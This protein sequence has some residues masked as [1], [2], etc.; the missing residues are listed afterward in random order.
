MKRRFAKIFSIILVIALMAGTLPI[1]QAVFAAENETATETE[2]K[3]DKGDND[4]GSNEEKTPTPKP[5]PDVKKDKSEEDST[6]TS[7][8]DDQKDTPAPTTIGD[9]DKK[10]IETTV[11]ETIKPEETEPTESKTEETSPSENPDKEDGKETTEPGKIPEASVNSP[12]RNA[13]VTAIPSVSIRIDVPVVGRTPDYTATFLGTPHY[14]SAT[15][16]NGNYRNDI[17]WKDLTINQYVNPDSGV[18][19]SEHKY[20]VTI[21]LTADENYYFTSSTRATVNDVETSAELNS[22]QLRVQYTFPTLGTDI[23]AVSIKLDAPVAGKKPDY[24]AMFPTGAHYSTDAYNKDNYLNGIMWWDDTACSAVNTS[25]GVFQAGHKYRV[26]IY[27]AV[28]EGYSFTGATSVTLNDQEAFKNL[29]NSQ[30]LYIVYSFQKL[31]GEAGDLIR[32]AAITLNE[33]ILGEAPDYTAEL[34]SGARYYSAFSNDGKYYNDIAWKDLDTNSYLNPSSG[35][36]QAGHTYQVTIFLTAQ[37]GYL[38]STNYQEV[39]LNGMPVNAIDS[40]KRLEVI[41]TFPKLGNANEG[42]TESAG[43]YKYKITNAKS[44]GS[45]TVTLIGVSVAKTSVSI[46]NNVVIK[47][48]IYKVTRI[49]TKAFYGN[50]AITSLSIGANITII[51]A[52]AFEGC[53]NLLKV[54]GGKGLKTIGTSAFAKCSKLK[55]FS[56]SSAVLSKIGNYAFNKDSKLKTIYIKYTTKL[57]KSGVKKSLKGSKVKTVKVKKSKVKKYKKYFKKKNSGRSVK[58]KK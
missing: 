25:S 12:R 50:K 56:I 18:F 10:P 31:E 34:P 58:V 21:F 54:T 17:I 33:P 46:Q 8:P 16:N 11:T 35:V 14:H 13:G 45:G 51:D 57:T 49:G 36:F 43:C 40:G 20:Q 53:S 23:S 27:L 7:E 3:N 30:L 52:S 38:F 29:N 15:F 41:Y 24:T 1:R 39:T 28:E 2:T 32:T 6:P 26:C 4:K 22:S 37:D 9:E 42:D 48:I 47:G 44:D 55:S 5:T 19:I